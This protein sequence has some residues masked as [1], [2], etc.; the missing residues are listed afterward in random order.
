MVRLLIAGRLWWMHLY[1]LGIGTVEPD[2]QRS[3][4]LSCARQGHP[5][6]RQTFRDPRKP[7]RLDFR[8]DLIDQRD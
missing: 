4:R 3:C 8:A 5:E 6:H 1:A 7:Q 2:L